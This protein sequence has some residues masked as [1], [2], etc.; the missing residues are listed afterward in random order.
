MKTQM[1]RYPI[2]IPSKGRADD[3]RT[4][5]FLKKDK[6]PFFLVIQPQEFDEYASVYDKECLL[7]LP[8]KELK[9]SKW[10]LPFTRNWIKHHATRSGAKRHWQIDDNIQGI[11]QVTKGRGR[12]CPSN[13]AL[14]TAE[15]FIDRYSNVAI[16]G[17]RHVAFAFLKDTPFSLNQQV[18]SCVLVWNELPNFW[19]E[20]TI[21]DTDYSLQVLSAGWCTVLFNAFVIQKANTD[22][23]KGGNTDTV[24]KGD[25]RIK[26]ARNLQKRWPG[27]VKGFTR[28]F[29]RP[30]VRINRVWSKFD[31]PLEKV[32]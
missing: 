15:D 18:Y 19:R 23:M 17:L 1:P 7:T 24:Y 20:E 32:K 14:A 5:E 28:R 9:K 31:T 22:S 26:Q 13:M 12:K 21:E 8:E 16:A 25:G 10:P 3:C 30:K 29:G 4:A 2:Y 27:V 6:V 11:Q